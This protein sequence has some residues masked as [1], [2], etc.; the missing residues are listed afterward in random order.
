[1]AQNLMP[2]ARSYA[3]ALFSLAQDEQQ[4]DQ[5]AA[6]LVSVR[7]AIAADQ[8]FRKLLADE[9][10]RPPAKAAAIAK[11]FPAKSHVANT[12]CLM[13][14]R[15]RC[16]AFPALFEAL[17]EAL[18]QHHGLVR[19]SVESATALKTHD[20]DALCDGLKATLGGHVVLD[21]SVDPALL[22]GLRLKFG[23]TFVDGSTASKLERLK[24]SILA[25]A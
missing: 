3:E 25:R 9:L 11:K 12:L 18:D 15:G 10:V 17:A 2:I 23:S 20:L 16:A 14:L 4:I 13:A 19:V 7:D 21:A 22:G 5:V 1:M 6:E 8:E 24:S